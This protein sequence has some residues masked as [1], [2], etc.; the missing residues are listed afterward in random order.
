MA[1]TPQLL[2]GVGSLVGLQFFSRALTFAL[3]TALARTLG[4][5]W[6]AFANVQLQLISS[7]AHSGTSC[8]SQT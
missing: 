8:T 7:T 4:P 2:G 3:N 1:P 6:Y 5:S